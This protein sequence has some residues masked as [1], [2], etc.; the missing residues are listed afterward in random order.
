MLGNC[1]IMGVFKGSKHASSFPTSELEVRQDTLECA[2]S[3]IE[4][5][6]NTHLSVPLRRANFRANFMI[7]LLLTVLIC[8]YSALFSFH[9]WN[10]FC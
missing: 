7:S 5:G 1:R 9:E 6:L 2:G 8:I 3:D 4:R 10:I